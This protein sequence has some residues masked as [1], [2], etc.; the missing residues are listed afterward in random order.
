VEKVADM[1]N[2]QNYAEC[3]ETLLAV[4]HALEI[5][6][7]KWKI[8][9]II[10]LCDGAIRFNELHR[11]I[12]GISAKMLSKELKDLESQGITTRNVVTT[13]FPVTVTYELTE[14]SHFLHNL[15]VALK[16][17]G[18]HHSKL[19]PKRTGIQSG[20]MGKKGRRVFYTPDI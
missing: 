9:I 16:N 15:I 14:Y 19:R 7:G 17:L 11:M 12:P 18:E 1:V 8:K 4:G 20:V 2:K 3:N 5:V 6:G 13:S 10:S